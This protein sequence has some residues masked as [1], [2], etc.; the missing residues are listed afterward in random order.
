MRVHVCMYREKERE[1]EKEKQREREGKRRRGGNGLGKKRKARNP[2]PGHLHLP[3][4]F[5]GGQYLWTLLGVTALKNS[6]SALEKQ[7]K[8]EKLVRQCTQTRP[9]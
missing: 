4:S 8:W 3:R 6:F 2:L 9:C 7:V 5:Y 1:R